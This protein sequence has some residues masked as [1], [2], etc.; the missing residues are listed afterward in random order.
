MLFVLAEHTYIYIYIK[1]S[2]YYHLNVRHLG[3]LNSFS[4]PRRPDRYDPS[5]LRQIRRHS[6]RIILSPSAY[7]S[8]RKHPRAEAVATFPKAAAS[9][10]PRRDPPGGAG[11][12]TSPP[13]PAATAAP[14]PCPGVMASP[15][16]SARTG[17]RRSL[18]SVHVCTHACACVCVRRERREQAVERR[19]GA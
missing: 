8:P 18:T 4:S 2:F 17:H 12:P 15:L 14:L 11:C 19:G 13:A 9:R 7:T 1:F 3:K 6:H 10:C 5:P 16:P